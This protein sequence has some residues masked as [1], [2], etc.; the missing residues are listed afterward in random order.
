MTY[1][2]LQKAATIQLVLGVGFPGLHVEELAV[3]EVLA[4]PR[5]GLHEEATLLVAEVGKAR[6]KSA[7]ELLEVSRRGLLRDLPI[8]PRHLDASAESL[9]SPEDLAPV[10]ARHAE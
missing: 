4:V 5:A 7:V 9:A 1:E 10:R 2:W 6:G 3:G 8:E